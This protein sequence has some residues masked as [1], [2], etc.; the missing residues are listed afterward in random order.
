MSQRELSGIAGIPVE[1]Y[2]KHERGEFEFRLSETL[3]IQEVL[4]NAL[5]CDYTLD[6]LFQ[7]SKIV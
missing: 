1:T 6:E 4:N 3:A 5:Q 2:K 7:M